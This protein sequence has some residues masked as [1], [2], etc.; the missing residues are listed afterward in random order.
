MTWARHYTSKLGLA[1]VPI[2][3]GSKAPTGQSWQNH[4]ITNPDDAERVFSRPLNI[5][6]EHGRSHTAALDIDAFDDAVIAFEYVGLDLAEIL[7][8]PTV[9]IVGKNGAKPL[10]DVTGLALPYWRLCWPHRTK[11]L[12]NG[13]P[14]HYIVLE[15]RAGLGKQEVLPP[16]LHPD[17]IEYTWDPAPP[18][19]RADILPPSAAL[20]ELWRDRE[21]LEAMRG[22]CP[23]REDEPEP[24]QRRKSVRT[25]VTDEPS[26]IDS[27]NARYGVRELLEKYGYTRRGRDRYL[28]PESSTKL[29]GAIVYT[30][31]DGLERVAVHNASSPLCQIDAGG[32]VRGV[33]AFGVYAA[34][35]HRGDV[36][37]AVRAAA[38]ELDEGRPKSLAARQ[39][40]RWRRV[41]EASCRR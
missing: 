31:N 37:T 41:R 8:H 30:G 34:Y 15:L 35:E 14:Q 4:T 19:T 36:R 16:S 10:Y 7:D 2:P 40:A 13:R 12:G 24:Q 26:V 20:L 3:R 28:P 33:S 23:W 32:T 18:R 38:K 25:R 6:C 22:A 5:G 29:A 9:R 27:F 21:R 39:Y 11:R 17:G 1:L